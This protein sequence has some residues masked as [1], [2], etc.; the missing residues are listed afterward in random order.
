MDPYSN[1]SGSLP[2]RDPR[3]QDEEAAM[4]GRSGTPRRLLQPRSFRQTGASRRGP[5]TDTTDEYL[6][7][8][9][10]E[11]TTHLPGKHTE[12]KHVRCLGGACVDEPERMWSDEFW[13]D[14]TEQPLCVHIRPTSRE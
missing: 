10:H 9:R 12:R 2:T 5:G 11:D 13:S 7:I 3:L 14:P 8:R 6:E 4:A 1:T